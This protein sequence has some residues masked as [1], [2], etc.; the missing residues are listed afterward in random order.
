[1]LTGSVC[2]FWLVIAEMSKRDNADLDH[3]AIAHRLKEDV[4]SL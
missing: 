3:D 2:S 4:V 1:M